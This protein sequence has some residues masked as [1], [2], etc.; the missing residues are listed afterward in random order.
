MMGAFCCRCFC[1]AM[2]LCTACHGSLVTPGQHAQSSSG[3]SLAA[4]TAALRMLRVVMHPAHAGDNCRHP[5]ALN[6]A[7]KPLV[8]LQMLLPLN[9]PVVCMHLGYVI[10]SWLGLFPWSRDRLAAFAH[11]ADILFAMVVQ[12]VLPPSVS[13]ASVRTAVPSSNSVLPALALRAL[14]PTM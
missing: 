4:G 10:I 14:L 5:S 3:P 6:A 7:S 11:V 9:L 13:Q 12:M 8:L 1:P 2:S